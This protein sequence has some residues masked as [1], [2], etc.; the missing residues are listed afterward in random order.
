MQLRDV[1]REVES[2]PSLAEITQQ[3]QEQWMKPLRAHTASQPLLSK[4]QPELQKE[5]H[6]QLAEVQKQ[7]Q[8]LKASRFI[9]EKLH[10]YARYLI[11]LKLASLSQ[12][13]Q[14]AKMFRR[15]LEQD[16]FLNSKTIQQDIARYTQDL[17]SLE[18][19]YSRINEVVQQNLSLEDTIYFSALP[20]KTTLKNLKNLAEQYQLILKELQHH[21]TVVLRGAP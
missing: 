20:H 6:Q 7:I 19:E 10:Q 11:E 8:N 4:L 16:Q 14:K 17:Q 3:F 2:L 13:K 12:D 21:A 9:S 5:L 1:K 15:Q 18:R